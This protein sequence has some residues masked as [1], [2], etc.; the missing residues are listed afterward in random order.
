MF[1]S[2]TCAG[3]GESVADAKTRIV[4]GKRYCIPCSE[5]IR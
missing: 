3:C 5:K 4:N 2:V 1:A